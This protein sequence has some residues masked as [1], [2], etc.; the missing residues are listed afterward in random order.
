MLQ[1]STGKST[2]KRERERLLS[3]KVRLEPLPVILQNFLQGVQTLVVSSYV[4]ALI[5]LALLQIV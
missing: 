4:W 1:S 2:Q 5:A 3:E